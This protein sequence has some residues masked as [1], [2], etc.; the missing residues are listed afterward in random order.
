MIQT[1]N[2][3]KI[4]ATVGPAS[5]SYEDLLNLVNAGV[6][7]FRFNFSH[8]SQ[9]HHQKLFEHVHKINRTYK[10]NIGILADL[11]GPK[12]RIGEVKGET[13][14]LT[15]GQKLQITTEEVLGT[16]E[17]IGINFDNFPKDVS[18]GDIILFDDG[19]IEL[20]ILSTDNDKNVEAEV[21]FG[22]ELSSKKGV[23]F[24]DTS[25]TLPSL[26]EKDIEDARFA[27]A[28]NAN[29]VALSFV[30]SADDVLALRNLLGHKHK[31]KIISKIEKPEAVNDIDN[32]IKVSDGV[33]IARGDLGVEV[34]MEKMPLI[35]K[36]LVRKC[37]VA[38]KPV[39]I[40]TQILDSMTTQSRPTRAETNDVAN[41]VIDGADAL[42]LSGE[43]SVG[44]HP[45][46]VV[47][48]LH[49]LIRY[50]ED[51]ELIYNKSL[52]PREESETFLSDAICYNACRIAEQVEANGIIGMTRSGYTAF[53]LASYRPHARIFIFTD[54]EALLNILSL[55]WGVQGFYYDRFVS[56]DETI[57]DVID[58]LRERRMIESGD[59]MINTASMPLYEQGRT[60]MLKITYVD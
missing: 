40:A 17:R 35:Q 57:S 32:I 47:S 2:R 36:N 4:I 8:G 10:L 9:E 27:F 21:L 23:N 26:T 29:W 28:N 41:D 60:N 38:A 31:I 30:R 46:K 34:P 20:R 54:N 51:Q 49:K 24:P 37:I 43:T 22:G 44:I 50:V 56:T 33:M 19:K 55:C 14:Q 15:T 13:V 48:T 3:T 59:V 53:M 7:L 18:E 1:K 12:I 16:S 6:N 42:M 11:Q 45:V 52:T 58:I 39:I 5:E 25:L